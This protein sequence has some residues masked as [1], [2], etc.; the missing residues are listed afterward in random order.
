MGN[1]EGPVEKF[2][3]KLIELEGS[4][5]D[6]TLTLSGSMIYLSGSGLMYKNVTGGI[7]PI[8]AE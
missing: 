3:V 7:T 1:D 5:A 2:R 4:T 8:V 6:P